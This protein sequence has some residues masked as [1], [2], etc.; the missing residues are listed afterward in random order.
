[1]YEEEQGLGRP[2]AFFVG[3]KLFHKRWWKRKPVFCM[4]VEMMPKPLYSRTSGCDNLPHLRLVMQSLA[5]FHARWWQAEKKPPLQWV[6]NPGR[7]YF[8]LM[9]NLLIMAVK[10]GFPTLEVA[11]GDAYAPV[12]AMKPL[13]MDKLKWY[14]KVCFY[15]KKRSAPASA[16]NEEHE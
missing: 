10:K 4:L 5:S 7:D 13:I 3:A 9:K 14:M 12:I 16:T 2:A 15:K 8:G 6:S 11:W 1:M